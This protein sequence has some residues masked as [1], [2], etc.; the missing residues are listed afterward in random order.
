MIRGFHTCPVCHQGQPAFFI[1]AAFGKGDRH[2]PRRYY[3]CPTCQAI[4]LDP[5]FYLSHQAEQDFYA[6]HE[7]NSHDPGYR[8]FHQP[9]VDLITRYIDGTTEGLDYGCGPD[10]A[11]AVMLEERGFEITRYDPEF[12][13]DKSALKRCYSFIGCLE[14]AEHFHHPAQEFTT[15]ASLLRPGGILLVQTGTPPADNAFAQWYYRRDPTHVVFYPHDCFRVIAANTGLDIIHQE[16]DRVIL[17][18]PI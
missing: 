17:Q 14:A 11:F 18:R 13:P 2:P 5:G 16:K 9:A 3:R 10:S 6:C 8:R 4:L 15:L 1:Q 7:N 12:F